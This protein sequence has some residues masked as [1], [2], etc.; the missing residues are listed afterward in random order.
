MVVLIHSRVIALLLAEN[1][2]EW[3]ISVVSGPNNNDQTFAVVGIFTI[4]DNSVVFFAALLAF[5][6][7]MF[8]SSSWGKS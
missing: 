1:F 3:F 4:I 2:D 8:E 7:F 5:I 6:G